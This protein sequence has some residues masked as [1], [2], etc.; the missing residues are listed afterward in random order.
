ME[1]QTA[2]ML[3]ISLSQREPFSPTFPDETW[4]AQIL[5][6]VEKPTNPSIYSKIP[7]NKI[8]IP[9]RDKT[10]VLSLKRVIDSSAASS[11]SV[12][13]LTNL[14]DRIAGYLEI[15]SAGRYV[16]S[17]VQD[18]RT[19]DAFNESGTNLSLLGLVEDYDKNQQ[20]VSVRPVLV[21]P[22]IDSKLVAGIEQWENSHRKY[23]S[24]SKLIKLQA[25]Q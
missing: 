17:A 2:E 1:W 11:V 4:V 3:A 9:I 13:G 15:E 6:R 19:R 14:I 7:D 22:K 16:R 21:V 5:R 12:D 8:T 10:Y 20:L 18:Q 23:Y 24:D 25:G